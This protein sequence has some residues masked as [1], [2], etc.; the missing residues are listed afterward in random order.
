MPNSR[1][2]PI[3]RRAGK[4]HRTQ[5]QLHVQLDA[6]STT[7]STRDVCLNGLSCFLSE[8]LNLFTKYGFRLF[9]PLD[10]EGM[11]EIDGEG[12]VVRVE[13][14]EVE[15]ENLFQTAF[16]FQHIDDKHLKTL[17]DF[18]EGAEAEPN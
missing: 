13:E 4:R 8:P 10:E 6:H 15:G 16:F 17:G 11:E 7:V 12:I 14:V 1:K 2:P 3:E 18:L 9:V 5:I